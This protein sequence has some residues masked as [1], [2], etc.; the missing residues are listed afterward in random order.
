MNQSQ[1]LYNEKRQFVEKNK[2]PEYDV[3]FFSIVRPSA[4]FMHAL[5]TKYANL[6]KIRYEI[7]VP[8]AYSHL[9]IIE[10]K[11]VFKNYNRL[12]GINKSKDIPRHVDRKFLFKDNRLS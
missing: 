5:I 8:K 9:V 2:I 1:R 6:D 7:S 10:N 4:K 12:K 3:E 11:F